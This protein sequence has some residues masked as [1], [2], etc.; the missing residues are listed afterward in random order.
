MLAILSAE[1]CALFK[2]SGELEIPK[3]IIIIYKLI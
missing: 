1:D 2:N 3:I